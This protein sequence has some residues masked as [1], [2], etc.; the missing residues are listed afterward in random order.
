M[1]EF[2]YP[3]FWTWFSTW[4]RSR[5]ELHR[6]VNLVIKIVILINPSYVGNRLLRYVASSPSALWPKK[7]IRRMGKSMKQKLLKIVQVTVPIF[8]IWMKSEKWSSYGQKKHWFWPILQ[9]T[10]KNVCFWPYLL[11]FSDFIKIKKKSG[12]ATWTIPNHFCF[13][14]FHLWWISLFWFYCCWHVGQYTSTY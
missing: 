2:N 12:T 6:K 3:S 13:T 11:N 9:I 14:F 1:L 8:F 4:S 10:T 7:E 5:L